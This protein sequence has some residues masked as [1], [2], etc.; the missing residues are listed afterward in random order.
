MSSRTTPNRLSPVV[1]VGLAVLLATIGGCGARE[2]SEQHSERPDSPPALAQGPEQKATPIRREPGLDILLITIDTLRADAL[3]SY[4]NVRA[5]TPWI[6][7]LA[8]GGVRFDQA[9]A[10]NVVTLPSHATILSGLLPHEHGV[11]D[12]SGFTFPEE[13]DTL[14]TIL[15]GEGYRTGAFISAFPLDSRFGLARGFDVYEDSF[16]G[17]GRREAFLEQERSGQQTVALAERWLGTED[18]RPSFA[19]VHLYD[20]HYPYEPPEPFATR[21]RNDPYLG[22]I[23]AMDAS[24]G[25]ILSPLLD[26]GSSGNTLVVLTSDHGEALGEHGEATHGIF[27]Y[28][29]TLDVPLIL[30]QPRLFPPRVVPDPVRLVD[31]L[32]TILAALAVP[33]PSGLSGRSLLGQTTNQSTDRARETSPPT[34]FEALSGQLNRGWAPLFGVVDN[35][36]KYI[37]LPIPELYDLGRDPKES[38]NLANEEVNRAAELR[39][40]LESIRAADSGAVPEPVNLETRQRLAS[41]GYLSGGASPKESFS[42]ED[43]PKRLIGLDAE[44]RAIS[45]LHAT[46]DLPAARTRCRAL[47]RRRPGMRNALITLA[48]IEHDL[49]NLDEAIEAMNSAFALNPDDATAL[50]MLASYLTQAGREPE[51]ISLTDAHAAKAR[52]D[53]DVLLTRG[54]AQART[55]QPGPA[56]AT[57]QRA[58]ELDPGNPTAFVY[59]GTLHLMGGQR[60]QARRA[61]NEALALNPTTVQAHTSLAI[62]ALEEGQLDMATEHWRQAAEIDPRQ[63]ARIFSIAD[64]L[65]SAGQHGQARP[66]LELV[67]ESAPPESFTREIERARQMLSAP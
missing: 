13:I 63:Y 54:L 4:G 56:L 17:V 61:F 46:G 24:L 25:A 65:W 51:A 29:S 64:R 53:L 31:L 45:G 36:W 12:N 7:R 9:R 22:D 44:L 42:V 55:R 11:R 39:S 67:V 33:V 10:H 3:G 57:L 66:L 6:D 62:M 16:V 52:P 32:P 21:F 47:L 49:G 50:A 41:L 28:A 43:D 38:T 58:R 15:S 23:A 20:P 60:D 34:Y 40:L 30:F 8:A 14:A 27:A 1:S 5:S 48:Q 19:W 26:A 59:L 35:N 2:Q 18:D 37:D